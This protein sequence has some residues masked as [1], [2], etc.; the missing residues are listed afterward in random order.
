MYRQ[1][2]SVLCRFLQRAYVFLNEAAEWNGGAMVRH[3]TA[4]DAFL[5]RAQV[6]FPGRLKLART[7]DVAGALLWYY[8]VRTMSNHGATAMHLLVGFLVRCDESSKQ[9]QIRCGSCGPHHRHGRTAKA[10]SL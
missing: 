6:S 3:A 7:Y 1:I 10:N 8:A 5:I 2:T 4:Q 9:G